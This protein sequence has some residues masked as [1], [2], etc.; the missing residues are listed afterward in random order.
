MNNSS[1]NK[2][3]IDSYFFLLIYI[4]IEGGIRKW[5]LP[6]Y[7]I[8]I[9][10]FRDFFIIF[11][12]L[13]GFSKRLFL[14]NST[15]E[16][17]AIFWTILIIF[18]SILQLTFKNTQFEILIVG[19]RNWILYL[20]VAILF[21]RSV[22]SHIEI[23]NLIFK[24]S[25]VLIPMSILIV[26]QHFLPVD[27]FINQYTQDQTNLS[28]NSRIS[29]V[30]FGIVRTTGTFTNPTGYGVFMTFITPLVLSI[31]NLSSYN[32]KYNNLKLLI[33]ICF[34]L[35]VILS[36]SRTV[37][38]SSLF[39]CLIYYLILL[40]FKKFKKVFLFSFLFLF[41]Y[42]LSL[43]FFD[44]AIDAILERINTASMNEKLSTRMFELIFGNVWYQRNF[45]FLGMGFGYGSN[46]S[47][48]FVNKMFILG[49]YE[50]DRIIGE[51][52]LIG[53]LFIFFKIIISFHLLKKSIEISYVRRDFLPL[54][55]ILTFIIII[56]TQLVTGQNTV[57]AFSFLSLGLSFALIK[58]YSKAK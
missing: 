7:N 32:D 20:W 34:A 37:I 18:W 36:G 6:T 9:I 21:Y 28:D 56:F 27:H 40:Y 8:E 1:Q 31:L 51:G 39:I 25:L 47:K 22:T 15:L 43:I 46:L 33:I 54:I 19:Y 13:Y 35:C 26:L 12:I 14:I 5:F 17:L 2:F 57:H 38:F 45:D 50:T 58:T 52:G 4:I 41:F 53:I 49:E 30:I 10:I 55:F 42:I 44:R 29:Q 3:I 11:L 48:I 24:I 23:E 16:S